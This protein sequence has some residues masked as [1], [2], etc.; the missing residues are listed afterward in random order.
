MNSH[1]NALFILP[2]FAGGGAEKVT[3]TLWRYW[4]QHHSNTAKLLLLHAKGPL[5]QRLTI[6][7]RQLCIDLNQPRLRQA[8]WPLARWI[9]TDQPKWIFSSL[10]YVTFALILMR[11]Y[12]FPHIPIIAREANMPSLSLNAIQKGRWLNLGYR[13]L[14]RYVDHMIASSYQMATELQQWTSIAEKKITILA[15]P[16][17]LTLHRKTTPERHPGSGLRLVA[18]GRLTHQKGFDRLLQVMAH[19]PQEIHLTLLGD[20]PDLEQLTTQI[21]TEQLEKKIT[22]KGFV[23]NPSPWY[24][25]A[26][27]FILPSRW[28]GMP[29]VALEALACGTPVIAFKQAGAIAEIAEAAIPGAVMVVDDPYQCTTQLL[30]QTPQPS[31]AQQLSPSLLP[32]RYTLSHSGNHF[33]KMIKT[34]ETA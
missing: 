4:N 2:S 29:N 23:Q 16:V 25:G 30:K 10:A 15:N 14:Y 24:A 31:K 26:D 28:E 33:L 5:Q 6:K 17:D 7:E 22:L 13:Y 1:N 12:F 34:I 27:L 19:L 21:K 18:S 9:K 20:G 32:E 11:P 8:I 3:L